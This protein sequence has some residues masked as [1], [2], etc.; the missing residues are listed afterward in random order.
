[1]NEGK[2]YQNIPKEASNIA[3]RIVLSYRYE[4]LK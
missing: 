3:L 2:I 4:I 1:M